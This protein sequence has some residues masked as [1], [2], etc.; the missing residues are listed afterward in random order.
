[1]PTSS[2]LSIVIVNWNSGKQLAECIESVAISRAALSDS[3]LLT[4]VVII[5]NGSADNSAIG[6][7][8]PDLNLSVVSN[9]QNTGF[10]AACNQG[11]A[12]TST[13][14]ILFLNPDT[15][16]FD[17]SLIVPLQ[18]LSGPS[19]ADFGIA[20]IQLVDDTG[21][22]VRCCARFPQASHFFYQSVGIDRV[23]P[24]IGH[25]MRDWDHGQTKAVD[26]VIGAFFL[27]R[28]NV[29]ER[30]GGFDEQFFVYF[31]EVDFSLRALQ[32]GWK[33]LYVATAQAYHAGGGTSN[34]I[35]GRRLFY[36]LRSRLL[37]GQKHFSPSQRLVLGLVT[38]LIEPFG[39]AVHLILSGRLLELRHLFEAYCLLWRDRLSG[40][41]P[42]AA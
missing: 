13:D 38:W 33:S 30:L 7:T 15:R 25:Y 22:V 20:S 18:C 40:G 1:M 41:S 39:R 9:A 16:L 12:L 2:S 31:E 37:F 17:N 34:Q 11:A 29:F 24:R 4:Q 27:V 32:A 14:Y 10:G 19:G 6:I 42:Q 5:D 26:Q 28:R 3:F 23:V 8:M 35:K 21:E 36:S